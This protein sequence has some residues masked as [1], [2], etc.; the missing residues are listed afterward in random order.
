MQNNGN[1]VSGEHTLILT[2]RSSAT[3]TGVEDVDCFNEQIVV[4]R[5]PLGALTITGEGLNGSQL[6]LGAGK[7]V[8]D[9]E[10]ASVEYSQRKKTGGAG[11]FGR[12]FS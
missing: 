4:L 6:N 2:G 12:L 1:A 9:G 5:T 7:L 11:F 10:I 3:I 8:V